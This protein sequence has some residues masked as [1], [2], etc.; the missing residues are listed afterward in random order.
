VRR[1]DPRSERLRKAGAEI[2]VGSLEDMTDLRTSM[3]N[4]QRAYFCPPLEPGTLRRAT[5]FAAAAR[6]SKLE[7]V[8]ALERFP[9]E[10]N[11]RG[12]PNRVCSDS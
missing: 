6:E 9:S 8:A 5:L 12:F 11:R 4:V 3:A 10:V 7:V 1:V 2:F